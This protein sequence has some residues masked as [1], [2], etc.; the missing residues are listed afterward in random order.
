[1]KNLSILL[2]AG[3]AALL[4][5]ACAPIVYESPQAGYPVIIRD[6][7]PVVVTHHPSN[8]AHHRQQHAR[9]ERELAKRHKHVTH[10][11]NGYG[12]PGELV[13]INL[14]G[15]YLWHQGRRVHYSPISFMIA[16]GDI[17]RLPS[18]YLDVDLFVRYENGMISLDTDIFGGFS[19]TVAHLNFGN[20]WYR[21]RHYRVDNR[22]VKGAKVIVKAVPPK[23]KHKE[24]H[25]KGDDAPKH[26]PERDRHVVTDKRHSVKSD[27]KA[28]KVVTYKKDQRYQTKDRSVTTTK[29][30]KRKAITQRES[31]NQNSRRVQ[32]KIHK[33]EKRYDKKDDRRHE[34]D[35]NRDKQPEKV[36]VVFKGGT[37]E[38]NG[39][40]DKLKKASVTL[41][42]GETKQIRLHARNGKDVKVPVTYQNGRVIVDHGEEEQS[43]EF[44]VSDKKRGTKKYEL[45]TRGRNRLDNIDLEV[46]SL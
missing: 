3:L 31:D 14:Q 1:M 28:R 11:Y 41:K 46:S 37:I 6:R 23:H 25:W 4:T 18:G 26:Q 42:K 27:Q 45:N 16:V 12:Q 19:H 30:V 22:H 34:K 17:I 24:R 29:T 33:D 38:R 32:A 7:T 10:I 5:T 20:D 8:N 35:L 21:E 13:E 44:R 39:R 40:Q 43:R 36:K 2:I 15:G 9:I